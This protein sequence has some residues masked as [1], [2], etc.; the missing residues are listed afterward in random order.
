MKTAEGTAKK[1]FDCV[2]Y[3]RE[4]R[5][6]IDR[7]TAGFTFEQFVE[8]MDKRVHPVLVRRASCDR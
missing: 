2:A 8:S 7:E 3:M 4:Q 6:R 5:D 1:A